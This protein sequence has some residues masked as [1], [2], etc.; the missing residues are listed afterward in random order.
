MCETNCT[1]HSLIAQTPPSCAKKSVFY[2]DKR[3][4]TLNARIPLVVGYIAIILVKTHYY[5][6]LSMFINCNICRV[7]SG[8][9]GWEGKLL[10]TPKHHSLPQKRGE[11]ERREIEGGREGKRQRRL[12]TISTR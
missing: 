4:P 11:G 3:L 10:P 1:L 7:S 5:Q 9:G 2:V 12:I 6:L 8:G